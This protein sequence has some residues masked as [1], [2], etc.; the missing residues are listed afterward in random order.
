MHDISFQSIVCASSKPREIGS[1]LT[2]EALRDRKR[3]LYFRKHIMESE[4]LPS[5]VVLDISFIARDKSDNKYAPV[6]V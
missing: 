3:Y 4:S 5:R 6:K 2:K 1:P